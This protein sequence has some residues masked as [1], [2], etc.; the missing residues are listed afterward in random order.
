MRENASPPATA[1]FARRVRVGLEERYEQWLSGIARAASRQPG[2]LGT[3]I[4]RPGGTG[5]EYV[6]VTQFETRA[7]LQAWLDSADRALWISRLQEIDVCRE[8][9]LSLAGMERWFT[10]DGGER[11]APARHKMA[12][13]V[14]LGL[15]PLVLALDALLGPLL[16]GLPRPAGLFLS[17]LVSVSTMVWFVLPFL[18][19]V[20][21]GWLQPESVGPRRDAGGPTPAPGH[22]T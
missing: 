17:L 6:A 7:S 2:S 1:V 12:A 5:A 3:T 20:F 16:A 21:Q 15:Y 10:F 8:E 22:Q 9:T 19:R 18:T 11:R 4:V 13:L 14:L